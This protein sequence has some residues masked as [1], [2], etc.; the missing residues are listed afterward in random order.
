M[1]KEI[2][3]VMLGGG[4]G[5]ITRYQLSKVNSL[6]ESFSVGTFIA[7][8]LACLILGWSITFLEKKDGLNGLGLLIAVGFC[9]GLSTFSTFIKEL[10]YLQQQSW[11]HMLGNL[12]TSLGVGVFALIIGLWLGKQMG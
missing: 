2:L 11:G 12:L 10:Y 7:N 5:A 8:I 3:L 6:W 4:L 9:G 1:I